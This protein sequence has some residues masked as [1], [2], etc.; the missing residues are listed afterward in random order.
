MH[1]AYSV[2]FFTTAS[3]AGLGL[4]VWLGL[5][6]AF[7]MLPNTSAFGFVAMALALGLLGAGLLSSTMHLGRPERFLKAFSP[8]RSSWLSREGAAAMAP[9]VPAGLLG[10]GWV[11]PG[12]DRRFFCADGAGG[13]GSGAGDD[14]HHGDDL[15]IA[16]ADPA[17]A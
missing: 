2:I 16:A 11:F 12:P 15:P 9:F 17:V 1:P 5:F 10:I 6:N 4:L 7:G 3:G 14:L 13:I 8:W